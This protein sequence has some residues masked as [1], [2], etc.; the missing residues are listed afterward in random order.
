MRGADALAMRS[1]PSKNI[2]VAVPATASTSEI[3]FA[4]A[5]SASP[6]CEK[7]SNWIDTMNG[8]EIGQPAHADNRCPFFRFHQDARRFMTNQ[9]RSDGCS[10]LA[11][12]AVTPYRYLQPFGF[13]NLATFRHGRTTGSGERRESALSGECRGPPGEIAPARSCWSGHGGDEVGRVGG[14]KPRGVWE[15]DVRAGD[16]AAAGMAVIS[17][18]VASL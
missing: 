2:C 18:L 15:A 5:A 8:A 4:A 9:N 6:W 13:L 11:G 17:S 7:P 12:M 14:S 1:S 3:H 16:N 10:R